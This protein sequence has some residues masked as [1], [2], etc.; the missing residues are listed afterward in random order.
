MSFIAVLARQYKPKNLRGTLFAYLFDSLTFALS[1]YLAFQLRFDGVL[2]ANY[3]HAMWVAV[4]G[5]N[6]ATP[7]IESTTY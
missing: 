5:S 6:P 2:P 3:L 1:V 4:A 7:T